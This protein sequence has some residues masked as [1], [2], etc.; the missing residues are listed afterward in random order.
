VYFVETSALVKAYVTEP[1]STR[2]TEA[3][4]LLRGS[5]YTSELVTIETLGALTK[6]QRSRAITRKAYRKLKREFELDLGEI[7]RITPV[8]PEALSAA[9]D[10]VHGY[11]D[12]AANGMDLVHLATL[13][14][15]QSLYPPETVYLMCSDR[16][17][18][19][20]AAARGVEVFNPEFDE[21]D[22]T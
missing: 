10:F 21:L 5:P 4:G 19:T 6:L 7:F 3:F 18:G 9:F 22:P 17:L 12:T 20:V 1:G 11:R 15:L 8:T 16:A 2:D 14:H 13:E